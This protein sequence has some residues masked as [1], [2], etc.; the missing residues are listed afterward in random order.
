M[1]PKDGGMKP[2][3]G[4]M[5]PEDAVFES[6]TAAWLAK[7]RYEIRN[8]RLEIGNGGFPRAFSSFETMRCWLLR[9]R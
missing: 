6:G 1:K 7:P 8:T 4:G 5:K 2:E 3:D 9:R